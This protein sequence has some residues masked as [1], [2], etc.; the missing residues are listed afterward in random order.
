VEAIKTFVSEHQPSLESYWRGIILFGDNVATYKFALG[1]SLLQLATQGKTQVTLQELA[2]PFSAALV[3]HLD[4]GNPQGTFGTGQFLD[5]CKK[6]SL[7]EI[8]QDE[9]LRTTVRLGFNNVIDAFHHV[10]GIHS[11]PRFFTDERRTSL[12]G[13]V[14]TD[15]I[16]RL[17]E[18]SQAVNLP[19]EVEAR[20]RLVETAWGL[21]INRGLL[22]VKYDASGDELFIE[23][24]NL[25]RI[26][27]TSSRDALNGYQKG[28]CFYC[29]RDI[30]IESSNT[31]VDHFFPHVVKAHSVLD[32]VD[33]VWNLVLA[34]S[35]CNL[36]K[37]DQRPHQK[38][39][40]RLYQRNEFY[41][42]SNH[43]LK[44]TLINQTG[45]TS[46]E[47]ERFLMSVY[48]RIGD[49]GLLQ[50]WHTQ[51]VAATAF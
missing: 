32:N 26:D 25:R 17:L 20:W 34:C 12:K 6:C 44:E 45:R 31:H 50:S 28:K 18:S 15:E 13:V 27:I 10:S 16:Y 42:G 11:M 49:L 3:E 48:N 4:S 47:R 38:Y 41:I 35:S 8:S 19:Y 37:S 5:A 51:E 2:V 9:L 24:R 43:P 29:F 22:T 46:E 21:N 40:L 14:L 1:R 23:D 39:L 30:E 7:G 33:G 36:S